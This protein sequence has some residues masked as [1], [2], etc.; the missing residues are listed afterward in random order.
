VLAILGISHPVL[1]GWPQGV[2]DVAAYVQEYG[3]SSVDGVVLVP[4]ARYPS[5]MP[6]TPYSSISQ[7]DS[8]QP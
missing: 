7:N 5:M 8:M 3:N 6:S 4:R 2:Q 1:V